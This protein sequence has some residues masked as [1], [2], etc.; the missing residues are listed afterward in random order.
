MFDWKNY[1]E[2]ILAG[3]TVLIIAA[4][5]AYIYRILKNTTER[6]KQQKNLMT[7][8]RNNFLEKA[9]H[10]EKIKD[11]FFQRS[12]IDILIFICIAI[13]AFF[14]NN[15]IITNN[16]FAFVVNKE[17]MMN[18]YII[19]LISSGCHGLIL[20]SIG[21]AARTAWSVG[22]VL[23]EWKDLFIELSDK[24]HSELLRNNNNG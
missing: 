22:G 15:N 19:F 16:G 21:A 8:E 1:I 23:D 17:P 3:L 20:G 13:F 24:K 7:S 2:N 9:L 10:Y 11:I 4:A 5:A 14:T 18:P 12:V 6:I